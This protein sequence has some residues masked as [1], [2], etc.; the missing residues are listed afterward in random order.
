MF[1]QSVDEGEGMPV[2]QILWVFMTLLVMDDRYPNKVQFITGHAR[3]FF[4]TLYPPSPSLK[5]CLIR[6]GDQ[7]SVMEWND[8]LLLNQKDLL[9]LV[10]TFVAS[11]GSILSTL[12]PSVLRS[13]LS[14][15]QC[16]HFDMSH[17]QPLSFKNVFPF[18]SFTNLQH[19]ELNQGLT[20]C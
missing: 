15:F 9:I 17:P 12:F 4:C 2:L 1:L 10:G 11:Q 8:R 6:T 5:P 16:T 18:Y 14:L 20:L 13:F 7:Q 19:W 3:F